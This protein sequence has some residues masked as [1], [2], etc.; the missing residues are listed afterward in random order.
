M[1]KSSFNSEDK[2]TTKGTG[3]GND[4]QGV[5]ENGQDQDSKKAAPEKQEKQEGNSNQGQKGPT[6]AGHN[7]Q[8]K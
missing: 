7:Q 6:G 5:L 8:K 3:A 1:G 4:K 2:V